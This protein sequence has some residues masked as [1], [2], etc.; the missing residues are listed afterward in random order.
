ANVRRELPQRFAVPLI[1][2]RK[3]PVWL[4]VEDQFSSGGEN[5]RPGFGAR[6]P[7]LRNLPNDFA[8]LNVD[9]AQEPLAGLIGVA[10]RLADAFFQRHEIVKARVR[11]ERGRVPIGGIA[12]AAAGIGYHLSSVGS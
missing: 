3:A 6:G 4:A 9:G 5:T 11:G 10:G 1:C 7:G 8:R 2:R 12:G